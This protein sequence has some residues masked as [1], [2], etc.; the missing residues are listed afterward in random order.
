MPACSAATSGRSVISPTKKSGSGTAEF[1]LPA[2]TAA[3]AAAIVNA[4]AISRA[5]ATITRGRL[6]AS[7]QA[8]RRILSPLAPL[9]QTG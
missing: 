7:D 3:V 2:E 8:W 4:S 1:A 9:F 6:Q 5:R